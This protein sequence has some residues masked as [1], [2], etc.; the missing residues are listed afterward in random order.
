[1]SSPGCTGGMGVAWLSCIVLSLLVMR[2]AV[3]WALNSCAVRSCTVSRAASRRLCNVAISIASKSS[4]WSGAGLLTTTV[5][6]VSVSGE[7]V[8]ESIGGGPTLTSTMSGCSL[9]GC[10][11]FF[12]PGCL[13]PGSDSSPVPGASFLGALGDGGRRRCRSCCS[14][15]LCT[16]L[17]GRRLAAVLGSKA[18]IHLLGRG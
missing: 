3:S 9:P 7:S 12:A 4:S 13:W 15:C 2:D 16:E 11:S 5:S 6:D 14:Q 8:G 1:M 17:S 18:C 10:G